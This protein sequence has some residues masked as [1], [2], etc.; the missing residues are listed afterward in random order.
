M[1]RKDNP[2]QQVGRYLGLAFLIPTS[3]LTGYVMGYLLD[4]AFHTKFLTLTFLLLGIAAG[5]IE[6]IR[7]LTKDESGSGG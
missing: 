5:I 6:L 2:M 3:A 7:E 1:M 4:K